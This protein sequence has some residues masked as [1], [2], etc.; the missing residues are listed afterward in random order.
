M[1][2]KISPL[3]V[4]RKFGNIN[5]M[6]VD[7]CPE[8]F[9]VVTLSQALDR[10]ERYSRELIPMFIKG[11]RTYA[12]TSGVVKNGKINNTH[13]QDLKSEIEKQNAD[14]AG[15]FEDLVF[16]SSAISI[17]SANTKVTVAGVEIPFVTLLEIRGIVLK[18][19][20]VNINAFSETGRLSQ[21]GFSKILD[22]LLRIVRE[23]RSI[24]DREFKD[25]QNMFE[26]KVR[27]QQ[28]AA[29]KAK[30]SG[31]QKPTDDDITG[32]L[33]TAHELVDP[34]HTPESIDPICIADLEMSLSDM[35]NSFSEA[36]YGKMIAMVNNNTKVIIPVNRFKAAELV[37]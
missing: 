27:E 30:T 2:T 10:R 26:Q 34:Y 37:L 6:D 8:G 29:L 24:F 35:V 9:E 5:P 33:K 17:V 21:L 23:R 7:R 3:G 28:D 1:S 18:G 25:L 13:I 12:T 20:S 19:K 22:E 31:K 14:A 15:I 11:I 32:A 16:I 4:Y 36:D